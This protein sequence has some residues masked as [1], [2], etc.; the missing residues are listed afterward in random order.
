MVT[1]LFVVCT[2]TVVSQS[3]LICKQAT[4]S[5]YVEAYLNTMT[6]Y[7]SLSIILLRKLIV[8][9]H[10]QWTVVWPTPISSLPSNRCRNSLQNW[11]YTSHSH[12]WL[13][14]KTALHSVTIK[15]SNLS[16]TVII[17]NNTNSVSITHYIHNLNNANPC[18]SITYNHWYS[19]LSVNVVQEIILPLQ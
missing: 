6:N 19:K 8:C 18:I 15:A 11:V 12:S 2:N 5:Q 7:Y 4:K 9:W 13:S 16:M 14:L 1:Q 17:H 10:R 3:M